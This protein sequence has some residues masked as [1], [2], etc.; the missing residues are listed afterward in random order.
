MAKLILASSSKYRQQALK[1]LGFAFAV[2][3]SNVDEYFP[4]RPSEPD[5]LVLHL[6]K[7]KAEKVAESY[8][9]GIIMG[10][11]SAG[12]FDGRIL[13][14]PK[15]RQEAFERLRS[16]SGKSHEFY[17]GIHMISLDSKKRLSRV[18]VTKVKMRQISDEEIN[19]YLD[20]DGSFVTYALGYDPL[21]HYSS[22]FVNSIEG[23]YNNLIYGLPLEAV[24]EMLSQLGSTL[25]EKA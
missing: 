5:Q 25:H 3:P 8:A 16:L 22:A 20:Q 1:I 14:K 6:S 18:V 4:G 15:S 21:G 23:S 13:E 17:T 9:E 2:H 10:F 19:S 11:D 7:L 12:W 24:A